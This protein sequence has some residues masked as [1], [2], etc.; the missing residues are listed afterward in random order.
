MAEGFFNMGDNVVNGHFS[1]SPFRE[2]DEI[3]AAVWEA[4]MR[5][6]GR[7][8]TMSAIG[9]LRLIEHRLLTNSTDF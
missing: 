4:I 3:E 1:G 2:L 5:F 9:V 7:V 8:S 6:E